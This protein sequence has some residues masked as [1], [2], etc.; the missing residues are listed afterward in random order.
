MDAN[1]AESVRAA[2]GRVLGADVARRATVWTLEGGM[3]RRSYL[4]STDGR[5]WVLRL[6]PQLR[7]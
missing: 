1:S 3:K 5:Q 7:A 4:V 6:S 2:L